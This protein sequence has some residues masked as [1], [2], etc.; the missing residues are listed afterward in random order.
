MDDQQ[1]PMGHAGHEW[2][3]G[4]YLIS[5][6]RRLIDI[7][8]VHAF[9]STSYWSPGISRAVV[10]R[11]I[12]HSLPFGLYHNGAQIGLVRVVTDYATFAYL[13]DVFVLPAWRGQG[14]GTWLLG[15]VTDD[16][17]LQGLRRWVLATRDAHDL[18]HRHGFSALAQPDVYMEK[19]DPMVYQRA[20]AAPAAQGARP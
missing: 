17:A 9:L 8:V 13:C 20:G 19:L 18:Y 7:D 6:D 12:E 2:R 15:V 1:T 14:L 16:A 11:A 3:Q 4:P 5:T 10:Q